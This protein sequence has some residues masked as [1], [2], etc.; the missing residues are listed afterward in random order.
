MIEVHSVSFRYHEDWVLQDVSFRVEKG[1]FVG[2]IGPNGSGKTT[3]LKILYRLLSPQKGEILFELVPMKKMDRA[4]IAKRIAVVA[5]ETHLLFPFSVLETVMMGRS[6]HLGHL[7]FESEKDLEITKKAMEWTK[8]L[9]FSERSMDELSGG[10]RKRVF[11]AR[12]LAQEP[13]VILLDEP[14]ANLDIHHQMDFLDLILTLNRERG[15]TIVM[16]SHDMNI[17]SEFCDRLILLQGGGIYKAGTPD[18][19]ITQENI[20]KVYGCEVWID[21]NPFSGMPRISL[22]KKG[23]R[24]R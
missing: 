3:L 2:V 18:E 16:A 19:V 15:L 12:A 9:P 6:P 17:A 5:Q 4:D 10:E 7:M 11:I 21:Q 8:M 13:E 14:T 23:V 1:E 24:E 20:E 22:L